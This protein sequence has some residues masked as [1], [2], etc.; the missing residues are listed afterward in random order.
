MVRGVGAGLNE[1]HDFR[2]V[3][4]SDAECECLRLLHLLGQ[5]QDHLA[6]KD[7]LRQIAHSQLRRF[8]R[9]IANGRGGGVNGDN[10]G[11]KNNSSQI[12]Y[13]DIKVMHVQ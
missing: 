13:L 1:G 9:A 6:G 8:A 2:N 10:V 3:V 11:Y 4:E 12:M 5:R 7:G